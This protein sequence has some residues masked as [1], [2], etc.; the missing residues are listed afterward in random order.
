M[1]TASSSGKVPA[2][3]PEPQ[4]DGAVLM[5]L[6]AFLLVGGAGR[7]IVNLALGIGSRQLSGGLFIFR[8]AL[9]P[10]VLRF[11]QRKGLRDQLID[12]CRAYT[13][14]YNRTMTLNLQIL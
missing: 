4:S 7:V 14:N 8:L 9:N 1:R 3:D 10:V 5:I 2:T 6:I 12:K 13:S 11:S